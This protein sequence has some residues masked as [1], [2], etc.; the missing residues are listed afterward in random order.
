MHF[1]Q[2]V[3][4]A[5]AVRSWPLCT[6]TR[7]LHHHH[8]RGHD[9]NELLVENGLARI[10]ETRTALLHG[11]DSRQYLAQLREFEAQ[12]QAARGGGWMF[13]GII[14]WRVC[15]ISGPCYCRL[16]PRQRSASMLI[17]SPG[18]I[19]HLRAVIGKPGPIHSEGHGLQLCAYPQV[20]EPQQRHRHWPRLGKAFAGN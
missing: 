11:R 9:L 6:P 13:I 19:D 18:K 2:E 8:V 14:A 1:V 20:I 15:K 16:M 17:S 10:Y 4:G 3:R 12:A 7:L 5:L